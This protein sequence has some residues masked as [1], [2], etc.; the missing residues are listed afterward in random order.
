MRVVATLFALAAALASATPVAAALG[1]HEFTDFGGNPARP[2]R[3]LDPEWSLPA[4]GWYYGDLGAAMSQPIVA[5]GRLYILAGDSLWVYDAARLRGGASAARQAA[6]GGALMRKI[7]V[8]GGTASFS[9]VAYAAFPGEPAVLYVGT[10]RRTILALDPVSLER[11]G[12][13]DDLGADL[14]SAPLAFPGD[15]VVVGTRDGRVHFIHNLNTGAARGKSVEDKS[16]WMGGNVT[17]SAVR[18]SDRTFVIGSDGGTQ[19]MLMAYHVDP[20]GYDDFKNAWRAPLPLAGLPDTPALEGNTLYFADKFGDLYRLRLEDRTYAADV[21]RAADYLPE[22]GFFN[23][24]PA[25]GDRHVYFT[26]RDRDGAG[27]GYGE[28]IAVDKQAWR[29]AWR[30]RLPGYGNTSPFYWREARLVLV[31]DTEG[32]VTGWETDPWNESLGRGYCTQPT[33][34]IPADNPARQPVAGQ[35]RAPATLAYGQGMPRAWADDVGAKVWAFKPAYHAMTRPLA[36][37]PRWSHLRGASMEITVAGGLLVTGSV[38]GPGYGEAVRNPYSPPG[39]PEW[40]GGGVAIAYA[41]LPRNVLLRDGRAAPQPAEPGGMV[42]AAATAHYDTRGKPAPAV[43]PALAWRWKGEAAWRPIG[44][45]ELEPGE[46]KPVRVEVAA[47]ATDA[48]LELAINHDRRDPAWETED[49]DNVLRIPVLV[50]ALRPALLPN[51]AVSLGVPVEGI[52]HTET[53]VIVYVS[54]DLK[55]PAQARVRFASSVGGDATATA[56]LE[57]GQEAQLVFGVVAGPGR[58]DVFACVNEDRALAEREYADNCDGTDFPVTA[59]QALV[60]PAR[61]RVRLIR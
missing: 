39:R 43:R 60:A 35:P 46:S 33:C 48:V 47:P 31:G 14:V 27:G 34:A 58:V 10:G 8:N 5:G 18:L 42:R 28:L 15:V 19:P 29:V 50:K 30:A 4:H 32:F 25:I 1:P 16:F 49:A 20:E 7:A 51:L 2:H 37:Q 44:E 12:E 56:R 53:P 38:T 21:L 11:R 54:H 36:G 24:S 22:G 17:G 52:A 57:P 45:L 3:S 55:E 40:M 61:V 59:T 9:H 13:T 23:A 26:K 41:G 6:E